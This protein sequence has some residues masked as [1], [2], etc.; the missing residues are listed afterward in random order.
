MYNI[1][2]SIGWENLHYTQH[3]ETA[4]TFQ[5][6]KI[7]KIISFSAVDVIIDPLGNPLYS[8]AIA[9]E[10]DTKNVY[11]TM[12]LNTLRP[13]QSSNFEGV[14]ILQSWGWGDTCNLE[15]KGPPD[16]QVGRK[17]SKAGHYARTHT[18]HK[19]H[20][21]ARALQTFHSGGGREGRD[22]RRGEQ[23]E[24]KRRRW[25]GRDKERG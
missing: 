5:L 12:Y 7:I 13:G 19:H 15:T 11:V 17:V 20:T 25:R 21:Q 10:S 22:R 3:Y 14:Y 23:R 24:R 1:S 8:A 4:I 9:R 16:H 2:L 18:H 6:L